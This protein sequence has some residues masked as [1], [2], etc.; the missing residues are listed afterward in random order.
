[1]SQSPFPLWT[2]IMAVWSLQSSCVSPATGAI[3]IWERIAGI[4]C[5][6]RNDTE[7]QQCTSSTPCGPVHCWKMNSRASC[8]CNPLYLYSSALCIRPRRTR[9]CMEISAG[10]SSQSHSSLV[11]N[12]SKSFFYIAFYCNYLGLKHLTLLLSPQL[13]FHLPD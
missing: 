7:I 2:G 6:I 11:Q 13:K 5:Y 9:T 3:L 8:I 4:Y 1:M 12:I 10:S